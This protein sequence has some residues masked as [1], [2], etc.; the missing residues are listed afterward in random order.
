VTREDD[1]GVTPVESWAQT[2][3]RLGTERRERAPAEQHIE[4][5]RGENLVEIKNVLYLDTWPRT[6][7]PQ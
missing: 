1:H 7:L 6:P 3:A 2:L 5:R 4:L